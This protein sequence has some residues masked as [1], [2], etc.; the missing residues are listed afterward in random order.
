M[1]VL[2]A[3]YQ[4]N[5]DSYNLNYWYA[6]PDFDE[7]RDDTN[8]NGFEDSYFLYEGSDALV[9]E[10][11]DHVRNVTAPYKYP[12]II[13]F[14]TELPKTISGKIRRVEIREHDSN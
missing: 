10:L 1:T 7:F 4:T 12:R 3:S 11:Q 8:E 9:R 14:A 5:L 13:E 6:N 2:Y